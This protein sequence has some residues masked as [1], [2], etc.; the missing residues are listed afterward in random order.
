MSDNDFGKA[1]IAAFFAF[2]VGALIG[3]ALIG[4]KWRASTIERGL[5]IYCPTTGQ[6]AWKG[7]CHE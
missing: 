2:V 4:T 7:E 5:A 1:L 6:W 3:G